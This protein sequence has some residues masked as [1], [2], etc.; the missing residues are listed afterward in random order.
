[1]CTP[2]VMSDDG[3]CGYSG[4]G[5][6]TDGV[7][8]GLLGRFGAGGFSHMQ[9][10]PVVA[11]EGRGDALLSFQGSA[12]CVPVRVLAG[13]T[14]APSD[15]LHELVGDDGDEQMSF[16]A[17]GLVVEDGAQSELRFQRAEDRFEVGEGEVGSPQD[18][19]VPIGLVGA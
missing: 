8:D 9:A 14:Q 11:A 10:A 17:D 12:N 13:L 5:V 1:M 15:H 2:M 18:F 6:D 3:L 7:V 4:C 16:G 19:F